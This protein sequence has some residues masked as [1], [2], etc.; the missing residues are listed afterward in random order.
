M[1]RSLLDELPTHGSDQF[2]GI[3]ARTDIGIAQVPSADIYNKL[4]KRVK[5]KALNKKLS[6]KESI[7]MRA[8]RGREAA[9]KAL[10]RNLSNESID[11]RPI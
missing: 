10:G 1:P 7:G 9:R 3:L 5:P 4:A 2:G 6:S 8:L 11:M